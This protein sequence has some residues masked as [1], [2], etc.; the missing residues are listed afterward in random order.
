MLLR[1]GAR[2]DVHW[3]RPPAQEALGCPVPLTPC[4]CTSLQYAMTPLDYARYRNRTGVA[5][6]LEAEAQRLGLTN[7]TNSD[8][9]AG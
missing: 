5:S 2:L 1:A 8:G 7:A 3:V 9:P 4:P 6:V